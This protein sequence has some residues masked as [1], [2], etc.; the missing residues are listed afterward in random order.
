MSTGGGGGGGGSPMQNCGNGTI[1]LGEEC[2]DQN[3]FSGDGCSEQC[4]IERATSLF[5]G[6][7]GVSGSVD[8]IGKDARFSGT[9]TLA[10]FEDLIFMGDLTTI[11]LMDVNTAQVT[12][13]AGLGGVTGYLDA[14]SGKDSRFN[15]IRGL[16][17]DG[18]TLWISDT[19]NNALRAI[20][21]TLP[22]SVVTVAGVP[23]MGSIVDGYGQ[24]ALLEA[25]RGMTYLKGY[26]YFL[27]SNASVLR[28]LDP[29]T[30]EV[31]T[32]AGA[33]H[34]P[35]LVD[36]PG[37]ESR[38]SDPRS[39]VSDGVGNLYI[40]DTSNRAIRKY[41]ITTGVVTTIAGTG[42]CGYADGP[43]LNAQMDHPRGLSIADQSIYWLEYQAQSIRRLSLESGSVSTISGT[44]ASCAF[45]CTCAVAVPGTYA[46][47]AGSLARWS[48]PFDSVYHKASKTLFVNDSK[49][50]IIR[51]V[52]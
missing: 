37:S 40:A 41:D 34:Q 16:A 45:D 17:T 3:T 1:D 50:F 42:A 4:V 8:G 21:L 31:K 14:S 49:N 18:K 36:G 10:I 46:E 6:M 23:G 47:G 9:T 11:R 35:G 25:P 30:F 33:P 28:R 52:Q 27:D 51:R 5:A 48:G 44:P 22:Y 12:T 38:F 7:P 32:L 20:S 43:G 26:V 13:I 29:T 15:A 2:D 39:I 19:N 24:N